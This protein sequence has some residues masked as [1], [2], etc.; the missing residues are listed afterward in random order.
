MAKRYK[1][2][3]IRGDGIGPEIIDSTLEVL[4]HL[5]PGI[6]FVEISAGYEYYKKTGKAVE[7]TF[8]D[9]IRNL[10]AVLKG[11][12]YTPPHDPN[13]KSINI[14]IRRELDLY[15]NIR[16][17][18]SFRGVSQK[19]FNIVIFRENTEGEYVGIEGMFNNIAISLRIIS[20]KGSR[21]ICDL[22][23]RY[24]KL[25][26]FNKV[27][28]VHKANILKVSDGLFRRIF[29]DVAKNYPD[30][31]ANEIIVDTAAYMLV[32]NPEDLQI[33]VTPNL[34]G[35]ILSDLVGGLMGSLGLCGSALIGDTIGV[36]E[37]IHGVAMDIAGKGI[38]NPVGAMMAAKMMLEYLAQR[39]TDSTL[40]EKARALENS[41][42]IVIEDKKIWTPDLGGNYKTRDVAKAVT[43]ELNKVLYTSPK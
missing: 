38:A 6:D 30:I 17:F 14:L 27:S 13:F 15:A 9:T 37:P 8:F 34:Y 3:V 4:Q 31:L 24:A 40:I 18:K 32:K 10:D 22:A 29:F 21:R 39:Y 23:F 19:V 2:G 16:P 12:L 28:V 7:D 36:F 11:P 41:I 25:L 1:I 20:E 5:N 35:D 33:L 43:E 26:G 42:Y